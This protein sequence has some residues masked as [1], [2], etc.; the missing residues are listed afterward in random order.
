MTNECKLLWAFCLTSFDLAPN[1]FPTTHE[2]SHLLPINA[3]VVWAPVK[4]QCTG[5]FLSIS[6]SLPINPEF[7]N[8]CP[9]FIVENTS[10]KGNKWLVEGYDFQPMLFLLHLPTWPWGGCKCYLAAQGSSS[11]AKGVARNQLWP[12]AWPVCASTAILSTVDLW[13]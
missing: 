9:Q 11:S 10:S 1:T 13:L 7:R 8:Y 5:Y 3:T 2:P 12:S 6:L 4:G